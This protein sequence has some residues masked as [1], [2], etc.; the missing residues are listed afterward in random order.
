MPKETKKF[1]DTTT[2]HEAG[3]RLS[4]YFSVKPYGIKYIFYLINVEDN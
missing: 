1:D 3:R 4:G 2:R